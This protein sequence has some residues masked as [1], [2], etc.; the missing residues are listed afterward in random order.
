MK[1][2]FDEGSSM[3]LEGN[4]SLLDSFLKEKCGEKTRIAYISADIFGD[5]MSLTK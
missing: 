5:I 3:L 4:V 2:A 1:K